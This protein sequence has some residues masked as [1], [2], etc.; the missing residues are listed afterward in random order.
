MCD[1]SVTW[2]WG[3]GS[4][5]VR[6]NVG[7]CVCMCVCVLRVSPNFAMGEVLPL[8][9]PGVQSHALDVPSLLLRFV[10]RP[11]ELG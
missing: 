9:D 8:C 2:Q 3:R 5:G 10:R 11:E 7:V 4:G 1:D 6:M